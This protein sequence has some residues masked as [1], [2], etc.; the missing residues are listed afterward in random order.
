MSD[1][2]SAVTKL[3]VFQRAIRLWWPALSTN[4]RNFILWLVDATIS[5][6]RVHL[7]IS[8]TEMITGKQRDDGTY[9]LMPCGLS[10]AT[11]SRVISDLKRR[12]LITTRQVTGRVKQTY[13][14]N[15]E[16]D[17]TMAKLPVPK[18]L[19]LHPGAPS[20][21]PHCEAIKSDLLPHSEAAIKTGKDRGQ[22]NHSAGASASYGLSGVKRVDNAEQ[23]IAAI[24]ARPRRTTTATR[25][26]ERE[27]LWKEAWVAGGYDTLPPL[28]TARQRAQL[29]DAIARWPEQGEATVRW[30]I[31]NWR[32]IMATTFDWMDQKPPPSRPD[33]G[34]LLKFITKFNEAYA[35]AQFAASQ[36][37]A[38]ALREEAEFRRMVESGM[39]VE[40]AWRELGR[41]EQRQQSTKEIEQSKREIARE[42]RALEEQRRRQPKTTPAKSI[43][44]IKAGIAATAAPP[45]VVT[46]D[47][48]SEDV[49]T[50]TNFG[51]W[52]DDSD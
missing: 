42:F 52:N 18:R 39:S 4:E 34:F 49:T 31:T 40:E 21:L 33:P 32:K 24:K 12:G 6:S 50:P 2:L 13:T 3:R 7:T 43:D 19:K 29:A 38:E 17:P 26:K 46:R 27:T 47:W 8:L 15:T 14:L 51:E 45:I 25:R 35:N 22:V 28:L 30:A 41:R 11:L 10:K 20:L 36:E 44:E 16:W 48:S 37:G 9:W 23:A 1:R 5:Y